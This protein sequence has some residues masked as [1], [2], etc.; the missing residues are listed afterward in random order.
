MTVICIKHAAAVTECVSAFTLFTLF[1]LL[2]FTNLSHLL[3]YFS[4]PLCGLH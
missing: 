3:D 2:Y 1:C 4:C